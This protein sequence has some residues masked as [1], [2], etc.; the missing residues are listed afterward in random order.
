MQY[1]PGVKKFSWFLCL[2][3]ILFCGLRDKE[4]VSLIKFSTEVGD[5]GSN[6]RT[7]PLIDFG[8]RKR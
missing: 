8:D 5:L 4:D 3:P 1:P 7:H 2:F 6:E